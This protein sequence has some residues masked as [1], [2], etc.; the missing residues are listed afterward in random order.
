[1]VLEAIV[2]KRGSL[3]LLDQRL[4]PLETVFIDVP[5]CDEVF[6]AIKDMIVRGAPAIAIAAGLALA[7][8]LANKPSLPSGKDAAGGN[9]APPWRENVTHLFRSR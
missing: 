5:G 2:Y 9:S 1:M 4:L 3:R 6:T 7:V 8:E